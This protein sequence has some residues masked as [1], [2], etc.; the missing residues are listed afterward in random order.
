M[1]SVFSKI[2]FIVICLSFTF[3]L[4]AHVQIDYPVGGETLAAG[5]LVTVRWH[6]TI[7]HNTL[8]WDLYYSPDGGTTWETIQLDLPAGQLTY[9]WVVP[10]GATAQAEVRV[11]QD[12]SSTDYQD[13]S[14][15][16]TIQEL[17][18][19][20]NPQSADLNL[21]VYPNPAREM[22]NVD[23]SLNE[24]IPLQLSFVDLNGKTFWMKNDVTQKNSIPVE[25]FSSGVYFICI[26]TD[27]GFYFRKVIIE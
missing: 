15:V 27:Q 5:Q 26:K 12:N 7:S 17:S 22:I 6:I 23:F 13:E 14:E 24:S 25:G 20:S 3:K 2:I 9:D 4:M 11:F 19:T 21:E 18:S 10:E 8:N 1:H 16:F